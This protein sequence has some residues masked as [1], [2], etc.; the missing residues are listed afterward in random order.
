M[1][2]ERAP[3]PDRYGGDTRLRTVYKHSLRTRTPSPMSVRNRSL[4]GRKK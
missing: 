1:N 4:T 3:T 2:K